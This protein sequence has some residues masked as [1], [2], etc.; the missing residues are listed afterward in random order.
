MPSQDAES[1]SLL[2]L[3]ALRGT[4][5]V[6]ANVSSDC[7]IEWQRTIPTGMTQWEQVDDHLVI[8]DTT[9]Q[10]PP[11]E[12]WP[13]DDRR[14]TRT[15]EVSFFGC[16]AIES[17]SLVIEEYEEGFIAGSYSALLTHEGSEACVAMSE[18]AG[19]PERCETTMQW[20]ALRM[21]GP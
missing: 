10:V 15:I 8:T 17:L 14:L 12:L 21:G 7:P 20:Q 4:W 18:E 2:S 16:S 13:A 11:A 3:E 19:L 9:G 1:A 6:E 5:R